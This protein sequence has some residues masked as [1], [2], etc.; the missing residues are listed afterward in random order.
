MKKN[1]VN[2]LSVISLWLFTSQ[3]WGQ[4]PSQC[5]DVMLQA[6]AWD[7]YADT[8]WTNL[9]SQ[10][11]E[12]SKSFNMMWV[13]Q[14][15]YCGSGN[16]MGYMPQYFFRQTS[17]FG[18]EAQL[19]AMI[20]AYKDRGCKMI[21]DIVINHRNGVA[22]WVDFPVET[23]NGKTYS[24]DL[25]TICS[26]DNAGS[27]RPTGKLDTGTDFD[28]CRDIDHYS[29]IVQSTIIDYLNFLKDDIGYAGWRYDMVK[30]Y[31]G[32]FNKIYNDASKPYF[33]VGECWDGYD[34]TWNWIKATQYTS[35]AFDFPCRDAIKEA[36]DSNNMTRLVWKANGTTDQPAGLIHHEQS[37]KYA[38][39]FVDNH[40]TGRDGK[41]FS[42]N[43]PAANAFIICSPGVPCVWLP[44]WKAHKAEIQKMI[45]ARKLVGINSES[46]VKVLKTAGNVYAAEVT[47][48]DGSL[49]VKIGSDMS[50]NAPAGYGI[51]TYGNDY[52]IWT[53]KSA[54]VTTDPT[55]TEPGITVRF[56][57]PTEWTSVNIWAWQGTASNLFSAWPGQAMKDLGNGWWSYTFNKAINPV[58]IVFSNANGNPQTEDINDIATSTDFKCTSST[59]VSPTK[60]VVEKYTSTGINDEKAT[61]N[62]LTF[63]YL[64]ANNIQILAPSN[65][66]KIVLS[67]ILGSHLQTAI[68]LDGKA[69][70][71]LNNYPNGVYLV[72]ATVNSGK[73]ITKKIIKK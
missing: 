37:K 10:A 53:T 48:T 29:P 30:G 65:T 55:P 3:A 45:D 4:V 51:A 69:E 7:S 14:S 57:K 61:E 42:G 72:T 40:D 59:G 63:Q 6:F 66:T 20:K 47:G 31:D 8:Q 49:I 58:N 41:Q 1:F 21:A 23:Y 9:T 24:W 33:S 13:P 27:Y 5:K 43:I 39:T 16:N 54:G 28:G 64:D 17:S 56:L 36:F 71:N 12:I 15:G 73:N 50:F 18:N 46:A 52:C 60:F 44:H 26:N 34:T 62:E 67:S 38:V 32:K 25:S 22:G 11:E 35:T 19:R 68:C 2:L 70:I